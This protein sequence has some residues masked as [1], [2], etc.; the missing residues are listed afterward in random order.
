MRV[1]TTLTDI[2]TEHQKIYRP[3]LI[4]VADSHTGKINFLHI[5]C[6]HIHNTFVLKILRN[7]DANLNKEQHNGHNNNSQPQNPG[8][9]EKFIASQKC[10][11]EKSFKQVK[12][13][14]LNPASLKRHSQKESYSPVSFCAFF[15]KDILY[16]MQSC[17]FNEIIPCCSTLIVFLF[18]TTVSFL[19]PGFHCELET[20][21]VSR[22]RLIFVFLKP[23]T[24]SNLCLTCLLKVYLEQF[25]CFQPTCFFKV[26][27]VSKKLTLWNCSNSSVD[28]M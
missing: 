22:S 12:C 3:V 8:N 26:V 4:L 21:V 1:S 18:F 27:N 7:L 17:V 2:Q 5:Y 13:C 11:K 20:S 28:V 24:S 10:I 6:F 15:L 19:Y 9:R 25:I 16:S 14:F 23:Q